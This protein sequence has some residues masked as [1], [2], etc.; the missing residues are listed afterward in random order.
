MGL[1][2]CCRRHGFLSAAAAA[3][4]PLPATVRPFLCFAVAVLFWICCV[5]VSLDQKPSLCACRAR[6]WPDAAS[7]PGHGGLLPCVR[8]R[9]TLWPA[10]AV[11][12]PPAAA[13][14]CMLP[15]CVCC[16]CG[17]QFEFL[18]VIY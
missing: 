13:A 16:R 5:V 2:C 3:R 17:P 10:V 14:V 6:S 12:W 11:R 8:G 18:D 7:L 4:F 1:L 15:L 9:G